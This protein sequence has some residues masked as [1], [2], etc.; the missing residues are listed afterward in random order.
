[1]LADEETGAGTES[2]RSNGSKKEEC[3]GAV[4]V[5]ASLGSSLKA[6]VHTAHWLKVSP[7]RRWGLAHSHQ[8]ESLPACL[9]PLP[10]R[11]RLL[12]PAVHPGIRS[13]EGYGLGP[14]QW[15]FQRCLELGEGIQR[16]ESGGRPRKVGG[17]WSPGAAESSVPR[18]QLLGQRLPGGGRHTCSGSGARA[19][20]WRAWQRHW[21]AVPASYLLCTEV[22]PQQEAVPGCPGQRKPQGILWCPQSF[23]DG[24]GEDACG[25]S[26]SHSAQVLGP[27]R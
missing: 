25:G 16:Q 20:G 23:R 15:P 24:Q 12:S 10:S 11:P 7:P 6:S 9:P 26:D 4:L 1:M 13:R 18:P 17:R 8:S 19:C 2:S 22:C 3:W 5:P 21:Q 14:P 27:R